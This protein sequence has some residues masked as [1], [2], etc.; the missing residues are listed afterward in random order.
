MI[1]FSGTTRNL[2]NHRHG[3]GWGFLKPLIGQS[4][5]RLKYLF[6]ISTVVLTACSHAHQGIH[7]AGTADYQHYPDGGGLFVSAAFGTDG[8]LWRIVPEKK[9]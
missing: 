7:H 5:Q 9:H 3:T 4:L 8:R 1:S 2:A 6:L